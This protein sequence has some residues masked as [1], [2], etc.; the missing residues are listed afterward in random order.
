MSLPVPDIE[1]PQPVV[2][3]AD[4]YIRL[5]DLL[6]WVL[7]Q[8]AIALAI[9]LVGVVTLQVV[10][11]YVFGFVYVWGNE[12]ATYVMIYLTLMLVGPLIMRDDHLRV[13]L[14]FH[15]LPRR[16][17]RPLRILQLLLIL[18]LGSELTFWGYRYASTSGRLT[19][20]F[21]MGFDMYWAYLVL[22]VTGLIIIFFAGAKLTEVV[23]D[24]DVL[25]EDERDRFVPTGVRD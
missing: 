25:E 4:G 12:L 19:Q 5:A 16:Y 15:R 21:S 23:L 11:R 24:P 17:R 8:V 1:P 22:P 6:G 9:L 13:D 20:S 3:L 18:F 7:L 10:T 14:L 2:R